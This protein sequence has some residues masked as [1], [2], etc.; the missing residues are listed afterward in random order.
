[1]AQLVVRNLDDDVKAKLQRRARRHGRSTEEE[2]RELARQFPLLD[3]L[4]IPYTALDRVGCFAVDPA[5]EHAATPFLGGLYLPMDETGDCARFTVALA[6]HAEALGVKFR[7][8][9]TA[10]KA[11]V[12]RDTILGVETTAGPIEADHV[13]VALGAG[14]VDFITKPDDQLMNVENFIEE[15]I[16]KIKV[17]SKAKLV[18]HARSSSE[19][20]G[21][22]QHQT[23]KKMIAI[24]A[25]TGGTEAIYTIL[26]SLPRE[27]PGMV[28]VQHIPPRFSKMFAERM[29]QVLPFEVKEAETGDIVEWGRVLIAPGDRH[30]R[31]RRVGDRFK[32]ECFHGDKVSGH[33]PSAD[34]LF[35][36]VA[37]EAGDQAVGIIL[38]GMG[39]DGAKGLLAMKRRGARTI[40]QDESS[41][42]V[43]G[44]P[45]V[46]Y[47]IGAV[48]KQ[49]PL[50]RIPRALGSML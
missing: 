9:C 18:Q 41:S 36:S 33:R 40:G 25:S 50:A 5:L 46:A 21:P 37:R 32:V 34:V 15:L 48:E 16:Q 13:V 23:S 43:Y 19:Q 1:M 28:I 42:V 30:M 22:L 14:A 3:E 12:E 31:V 26:Q 39:Y 7:Y 24:A 45:K 29:N 49:V 8:R 2:V 20:S 47:E 6:R 35:E 17:A 10:G 11:I 38:T 44:M 27:M 4:G